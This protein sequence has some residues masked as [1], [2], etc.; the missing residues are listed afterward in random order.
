VI[1]LRFRTRATILVA[2]SAIVLAA[3]GGSEQNPS[4]VATPQPAPAPGPAQEEVDPR[5]GGVL[6]VSQPSEPTSIYPFRFGAVVDWNVIT[7]MYDS[8]VEFDLNDYSAVPALAESWTT[9]SD[10]KTWEFKLRSGVVFHNGET[11]TSDNVIRS[12]EQAMDPAFGRTAPLLTR[13]SGVTAV[14]PLTV[15]I[16][17]TEPERS[18]LSTLV[19]VAILPTGPS[20]EQL[21]E[22]PVGTGPFKFVQWDRN[23]QIVLE[24]NPDYWREGLPLLDGVIFKTIPDGSVAA[25][26]V[27]TGDVH[28]MAST[29]LGQVGPLQAAG[30][31]F[32]TTA[33]GIGNGFYHFHINTRRA[34]W[35][36]NPT[37]RQAMSA[38]INRQAAA[39]AVFGFMIPMNNPVAQN[40]AWLN[41]DAVGFPEF[42]L[43]VA[44]Q[45]VIDAGYPNGVNVGEMI[46]CG[47][48]PEFGTLA[49]VV[50]QQARAVGI[51]FTVSILDLGTYVARTLGDRSG[52]FSMAFCGLVPKPDEY[53]LINHTYAKLFINAQGY[54]DENPAFF[55]VL[56]ATRS[57]ADDAEY[58]RAIFS[59]QETIMESQHNVVLGGRILPH[60]ARPEVRDFLAHTQ[61]RMFLTNVWLEN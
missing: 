37:L 48:G 33:E 28:L 1:T 18:L 51:E 40:V 34:P 45:L 10:G 29:P 59:L 57:I 14:D 27:R 12:M 6:V 52:D 23:Q 16:T 20:L 30:M 53:D 36:G 43:E 61:Q 11:L 58:R 24:R 31:Q 19:D 46:V 39:A 35:Q 7:A 21:A 47:L 56:N 25:L 49:Q 15:R 54:I 22:E 3:C 2:C 50:Q 32:F 38:A 4:D 44:Q 17:L 8:L 9:S 26:Q 41:P 13:V 42:D 55:E 60:A 5:R